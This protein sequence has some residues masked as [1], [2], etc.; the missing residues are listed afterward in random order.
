MGARADGGQ[1]LAR[2]QYAFETSPLN[3]CKLRA[4]YRS[5]LTIDYAAPTNDQPDPSRLYSADEWYA[6]RKF[7]TGPGA[8]EAHEVVD[9]PW[10][11][12]TARSLLNI[13]DVYSADLTVRSKKKGKPKTPAP[14][15]HLPSSLWTLVGSNLP[16]LRPKDADGLPVPDQPGLI[17]F[18]FA[19]SDEV[20]RAYPTWSVGLYDNPPMPEEDAALLG[21]G[22]VLNSSAYAYLRPRI[23]WEKEKASP[24]Q[25][26]DAGVQDMLARKWDERVKAWEGVP[27][28]PNWGAPEHSPGSDLDSATA[29]ATQDLLDAEAASAS[30]SAA[31]LG[32]A[33]HELFGATNPHF[34]SAQLGLGSGGSGHM[35]PQ[36]LESLLA[37]ASASA[38]GAGA[39]G[40]GSSGT[41]DTLA[42]LGG[43][44][45]LGVGGALG[46]SV[47]LGAGHKLGGPSSGSSLRARKVAKR[48]VGQSQPEGAAVPVKRRRLDDVAGGGGQGALEADMGALSGL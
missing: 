26:D 42:G 24:E 16:V 30:A 19:V 5:L 29:Q 13:L 1:L 4:L 17:I 2:R 15:F 14:T 12:D 6:Y 23:Q 40:G 9:I 21:L 18:R 34:L 47:G 36:Q 32:S 25:L 8:R 45:S 48:S 10:L 39:G 38:S 22:E 3:L 7:V 46:V 41:G 43:L 31:A 33:T 44:G 37:S 11:S 20:Q 27:P 35:T 28:A